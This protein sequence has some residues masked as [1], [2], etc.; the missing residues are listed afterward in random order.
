MYINKGREIA[1]VLQFF[2][3]FICPF[4]FSF[5]LR[6]YRVKEGI[7]EWLIEN[8]LEAGVSVNR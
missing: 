2:F 3:P 6:I 5:Q 4:N 7:R 1:A 8:R